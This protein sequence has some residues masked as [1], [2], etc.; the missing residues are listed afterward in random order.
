MNVL[1]A[2]YRGNGVNVARIFPEVMLKCA[3]NDQFKVIFAP[4]SDSK[5]SS[6]QS[7][8]AAG[9]AAGA[10]RTLAFH[11]LSV[12]RTRMA[13]DAGVLRG[14]VFTCVRNT[15]SKES[16]RGFY[17]GLGAAML[18]TAPYLAVCFTLYDELQVC[19]WSMILLRD[20]LILSISVYII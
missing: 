15:W 3:V 20:T 10:L 6:I 1:Q 12:I 13:A 8:L 4:T 14:G 9:A 17:G 11:P 7:K 5:Q 18:T 2:L 16:F 19:D